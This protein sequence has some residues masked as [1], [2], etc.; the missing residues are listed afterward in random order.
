[1]LEIDPTKRIS[2]EEAIKHPFFINGATG[3]E[4]FFFQ[5]VSEGFKRNGVAFDFDF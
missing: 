5:Q 3:K 4:S 1:M 2:M